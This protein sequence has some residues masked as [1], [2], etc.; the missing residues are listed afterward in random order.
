MYRIHRR[1]L[2]ATIIQ[3]VIFTIPPTGNGQFP[4]G[5]SSRPAAPL[6]SQELVRLVYELPKYPEKLAD[7]VEAVRRRGIGFPLTD[8]MRS[9]VAAKSGSDPLLR[10]T[11]EEAERRRLNPKTEA[12]PSEAESNELLQ[13]TKTATLG[14]AGAMPDFIVRQLIKRSVAYGNTANWLSQDTL[15][16]GVSYRQNAGEE[17]KVLTMNGMP[18]GQEA[19][20]GSDYSKYVGGTTSSGAEYVTGLASIFKDEAQA[21]FKP[22]D[23]DVIRGRRTIIYEYEVRQPLS[24]L[25]LK[26]GGNA[27][28]I[29]GS[30]GRVWVDR[31]DNRVLRFEQIATEIPRDFPI[32]AASSLIDF[33]WVVINEKKHLLPINANILLTSIYKDHQLV[34]SRND[35]RFRGYQKFG[36]ELKVIDEV[37]DSDLPPEK[38]EKPD[39]PKKPD[40][41]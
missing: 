2:L 17:Y 15:T 23:T 36:A 41:P 29:V 21:T 1:L 37:D 35:V 38:P 26:A 4:D 13:R 39:Q 22:V 9:L 11:L 12:P 33:D 18:L 14:A 7:V 40:K 8:G 32:T 25:E 16:I 24:N 28:A 3:A 20:A 19:K 27:N 34:Q 5:Q 31:E 30:R 6:T 10:R